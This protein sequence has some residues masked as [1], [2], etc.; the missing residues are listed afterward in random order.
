MVFVLLAAAII[1]FGWIWKGRK[2]S[3]DASAVAWSEEDIVQQDSVILFANQN[4]FLLGQPGMM[5]LTVLLSKNVTGP[6][7]IMDD[8]DQELMVL[9]NDGSG[10]LKAAVEIYEQETRYG[11]LRA[12]S[13][14]ETSA[15]I[16]FCVHPEVT[17]EMAN[18]LLEVCTDLG[19]YAAAGF[20]NP[21]EEESME[22]II[23]WLEEDERVRAV[24]RAGT[25]LLFETADSL[26]GS[27]G[28]NQVSP[29]SFGFTTA[30]K[31]FEDYKERK[32]T[33]GLFI[34]SE[35]PVTNMEF[36]HLS[37]L[38]EDEGVAK[39]STYFQ[40]SE[41]KLADRVGAKLIWSEGRD[42][43]NRI[44]SGNFTDHG[45]TVLNTHGS[46]IE[47]ES[48][49]NLLL[50]EM[51]RKK[52]EEADQLLGTLGYSATAYNGLWGLL[53]EEG[54]LR[55][56]LDVKP[57]QGKKAEEY[58]LMMSSNYLESALGDKVFD[59]TILYFIVCYAK[60]DDEMVN[61]LLR[62]G[63][64]AFI[65]CRQPLDAGLS[66]AFLE[67]MAEIM[68]T[69]QNDYSYGTLVNLAVPFLPSV[70][71]WIR[72][73]VCPQKEDYDLYKA[74][75]TEGP[76]CYK[77]R[78]D[79][80]NRVFNG[81]GAVKGKV[82]DQELKLVGDAK[83]TLYRWLNHKFSEVWSGRTDSDGSFLAEKIPYGIYGIYAQKD[84]EEGFVTAVLDDGKEK[85]EA[86]DIIL[87]GTGVENNGG[88]AVRYKNNL[89]YWK[90]SRQSFD[91]T[92]LFGY[93]SSMPEKTNQLVCRQRDGSENVLLTAKGGGPI[94]ISGERIYLNN[95]GGKLFSVKLDGSDRVEHGDF[96]PWAA[97]EKAGTLIGSNRAN[98]G[99]S[100]LRADHTR[101]T[102][103][104]RRAVFLHGTI[105]GFCYMS[106]TDTDGLGFTLYQI[107]IDGSEVTQLDSVKNQ[108]SSSLGCY[109]CELTKLNDT[110]YYS[111]G[112]YA[113]TGGFF[114]AGGINCVDTDGSN[115]K[116]CVEYGTLT[117][118][119]FQVEE[120]DGQTILYYIDREDMVGS[121]IGYWADYPYNSC[122]EKNL[123]DGKVQ[124][125]GHVLSRPGSFVCMDGEI[126]LTGKNSAAYRLVIPK[127]AGFG[128]VDQPDSPEKSLVLVS[129]LDLIG[130]EVFF[131]VEW[132]SREPKR[133]VGW[134]PGYVREK[135]TVYTMKTGDKTP[136]ELY[137]Y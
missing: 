92:G 104:S 44:V 84:Q 26:M 8:R 119:E 61:L 42:S 83:V 33:G 88:N 108:D 3:S 36:L 56:S 75:R 29:N 51:G 11:R 43:F 10:Q 73:S 81:Q 82:L 107:P 7:T 31:A 48:G 110:I 65:G 20:E 59:N 70:D 6:V 40:Q 116:V 103:F 67:Q 122:Q 68:G 100:I 127:E 111:Y 72:T 27:Y 117:A 39:Y 97:D 38:P 23:A 102:I 60:S 78:G 132:S 64:S 28:L 115:R 94:F 4:E 69:R 9:E 55:W 45:F 126:Y 85:T 14:S 125:S 63:A 22:K 93:Y 124:S 47:R 12:L 128:F 95:G 80:A 109:V 136:Q 18:R 91:S 32:S 66:V 130:D 133:D 113:G 24:K 86:E 114:Q 134:R 135:S 76:L 50:V 19:D 34:P 52:R 1:L 46:V 30:E 129:Q 121:Y 37:P 25:G 2:S 77:F 105:D 123:T 98:G 58:S 96:E 16:S 137:S 106:V 13:G 71:Q 57:Q 99:V 89:Y 53:D 131:T 41:Q 112:S 101:K 49:G 79:S 17:E 120:K 118:E 74:A 21:F 35:I 62:H 15:P 5:E 87:N 54:T 90:Y